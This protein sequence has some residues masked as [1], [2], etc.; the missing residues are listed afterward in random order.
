MNGYNDLY[1]NDQVT[2]S[3]TDPYPSMGHKTSQHAHMGTYEDQLR[4]QQHGIP[5][6]L[7]CAEGNP[8]IQDPIHKSQRHNPIRVGSVQ[9][10]T[11]LVAMGGCD[12]SVAA[13]YT[14]KPCGVNNNQGIQYSQTGECNTTGGVTGCAKKESEGGASEAKT[15]DANTLMYIF[16]FIVLIFMCLHF[17]KSVSDLKASTEG[18]FQNLRDL[19]AI[20]G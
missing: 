2:A 16:I 8:Y 20:R 1:G 17:W 18:G 3:P 12:P 14:G 11:P 9:D 19:I 15:L 10:R 4:F 5:S 13:M 7:R 6:R